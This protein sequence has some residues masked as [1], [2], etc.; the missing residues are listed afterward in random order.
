MI[1]QDIAA[2]IFKHLSIEYALADAKHRLLE[3]SPGVVSYVRRISGPLLGQPLER[4]F[5]FLSGMERELDRV[6][7]GEMSSLNIERIEWKD[8]SG[9]KIY[10]SVRIFPYQ[11]GLLLLLLDVTNEARLEQ[12][13]TQQRNELNLLSAELIRSRAELNELLHRFMPARAADQAISARGRISP[14]GQKRQVSAL[15]ADMRGF[16]TLSEWFP[17]EELLALLNRHFQVMGKIIL[18]WEGEI[19]NY[20]GDM[21]MA[22][23]N[24]HGDQ[25]DHADR[26]IQA[27]LELQQA[28]RE[29]FRSDPSYPPFVFD[30]GVG[31]SSGEAAVGYLGCNNRLEYT[32]L[33]D[34]I[35]VAAR[36][37]SHAQSGQ[38][39][40]T[41]AT[42]SMLTREVALSEM[43]EVTLC[44][45]SRPIRVYEVFSPSRSAYSTFRKA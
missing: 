36:L 43:G 17:P 33:G 5:D 37:S 9:E 42:R 39:L 4:L 15:F 38:V 41:E 21:L 44:G 23:F 34:Q 40:I 29:R 27:A 14:G 35:N 30:F 18:Q 11:E 24:A 10:F 8:I 31:I 20:A 2:E 19:T 3:Y 32:A 1:R 6:I 16:T 25:P 28:L 26:A 13:I 7:A 12:R 22:I 45:L